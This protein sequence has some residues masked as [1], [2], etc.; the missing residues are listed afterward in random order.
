MSRVTDPAGTRGRRPRA[1]R[2]AGAFAALLGFALC[3]ACGEGYPPALLAGTA[4][5]TIRVLL[6]RPR[7]RVQVVVPGPTWELQSTAGRSYALRGTGDLSSVITAGAAGIVVQG[8]DTGASALRLRP[9]STFDLDG[10]R[11]RGR[12]LLRRRGARLECVNEVDL[13][14]YIAGVI[15][16]EVGPH[17]EPATYR[18][19]AVTARTYAYMRLA[20]PDAAQREWH[21]YDDARSQVYTG[22]HVPPEYGITYEEMARRAQETRGV[23]LTWR[24][25][26]FPTYYASTCGGHTTEAAT[27]NLDPGH[28]AEVLRG[29]PCGHCGTSKYFE[30]TS[31]VR[32][33]DLLAALKRLKRPV[34]SP[35][36]AVAVSRR[37]RGGWAAEVSLRAGP[38][39]RVTTMPGTVFRT[40]ARLR[41]H[42]IRDIRRVRGGWEI[43]GRGWGHGV[44][45]CQWGAIEMGRKGATETEILRFY[46]PGVAFTKVY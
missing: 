15:G 16:N 26:P 18:A 36:H 35:I 29:V 30:W 22:T 34:A 19:Q 13:E 3:G 12:L 5:P 33:A 46:Y 17:A 20:S 6:G 4:A 43:R 42:N 11:Y 7:A 1:G 37:G 40:A 21:V 45:M 9:L 32:D 31:Q 44:G 38:G 10:R 27:S 2:L 24:G 8:R 28:A 25:R 23:I 39:R 14:T 41:S